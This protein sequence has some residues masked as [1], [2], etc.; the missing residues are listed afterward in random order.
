MPGSQQQRGGLWGSRGDGRTGC[1]PAW[2]RS[3]AVAVRPSP[4][5]REAALATPVFQ[6]PNS[7]GCCGVT[8][9]PAA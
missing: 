4:P 1:I 2:C 3:A 5:R 6:Q 7:F 8:S 9:V